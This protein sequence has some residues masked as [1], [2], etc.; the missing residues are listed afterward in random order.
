LIYSQAVWAEPRAFNIPAGEAAMELREFAK[1][2]GLQLLF[3]FTAVKSIKTHAVVGQYEPDAALKE[4]LRGTGLDF[5]R[6]NSQT[7]AVRQVAA[8]TTDASSAQSGATAQ[9]VAHAHA[10][11]TSS[12]DAATD[13]AEIV[14][15]AQKRSERLQD[16][17]IPVTVVSTDA[18]VSNNQT[19]LQDY[20]TSIPGL[21]VSPT[22]AS[23]ANQM[24]TIRGISPAGFGNPTVGITIDDVPYGSSTNLGGGLAVEDIDP[25]DLTRV[26]VLRGPQGTLY[27]ANSLGGLIKFVTVDPSTDRVRGSVQAGTSSVYNGADLGYN[28]RASINMPVNDTLAVRASG[29]VREDPGFIDNPVLGIDGINRV[30][31]DG[32]R[33]SALWKPS[34]DISLKL[35]AQLQTTKGYGLNDVNE[36]VNGYAGPPLGD[37][38]QNYIRGVGPYFKK[39]QA[40]AAILTAK[41]G[42]S[43][44]TSITG[45]NVNS[46]QDSFDLSAFVGQAPE[47]V[48]G[49]SG[50][51]LINTQKTEKFTQEVRLATP[52]GQK[53]DWLVGAFYTHEESPATELD[54]A[55]NTTTGEIVGQGLY[56]AFPSTYKEYAGFT[57]VTFHVTDR[58][59][60]QV[61]GRE[62]EIEQ[63]AS[64]ANIGPFDPA[65]NG[66]PSPIIDP[67]VEVKSHAF[68]YLVTP[69]FKVSSDLM[70]YARL[71]SGYR[72]GGPNVTPGTPPQ[73]RPDT[74]RNYE[75]GVKGD[76]LDHTLSIDSSVYYV[77][78]RD[79]QISLFNPQ[80]FG[81]YN[82]NA[83]A[84]KSEGLEFSAE[85]RPLSGMKIDGWV[86]WNDGKLTEGFPAASTAIGESGD[87]LPFS[88]R[89]SGKLSLEQSFPLI[90]S[91]TG[92]VGGS[93]SYVGDQMGSFPSIFAATPGRQLYPSYAR[94]DVR[95]GAEYDAWTANLYVNNLADK[96][97]VIGGGIG[98]FPAYA[99]NVI[100]PRTVGLS[101]A[102]SF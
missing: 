31:A 48:F 49:V 1:Q 51:Q 3:D 83:G 36:A 73:Y 42:V 67:Q 94:F 96:R 19:R 40:Y 15:T 22:P 18:L 76:F 90:N 102:W 45:F 61:G 56:F 14:V 101:V 7:V 74:T 99:F 85:A 24:L 88:S 72:A 97:A 64:S 33:L 80:N 79:I 91:V 92:L 54:L 77:N 23:G 57:D 58:F 21:I 59:D 44:L 69:R 75:I 39:V 28:V 13:L 30:V 43:E 65:V 17:P 63:T 60:I 32:G 34:E 62:S 5:E 41:L 93:V 2:S 53:V 20:Y 16:V 26:E 47:Q 38:Q 68:T 81:V 37:L 8:A 55:E 82:T 100:Q 4:M 98:A 9:P 70:L 86:A 78:W 50:T 84:A 46:E 11:R 12:A 6:V 66:A 95:A 89:F 10:A 87:R 71:A 35:S 52:I 25:G 27:G 29:F